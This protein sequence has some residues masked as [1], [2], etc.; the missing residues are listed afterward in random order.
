MYFVIYN[1]EISPQGDITINIIFDRIQ[2][3]NILCIL[4]LN[5]YYIG[6]ILFTQPSVRMI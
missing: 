1:Q 6:K 5:Q 3:N 2:L 4:E